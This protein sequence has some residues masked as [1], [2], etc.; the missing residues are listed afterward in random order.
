MHPSID[1]ECAY[2]LRCG[3]EYRAEIRTCA[4]C[5]IALVSG[6]HLLARQSRQNAADRTL[7]IEP[8]EPL[9]AVRRGPLA[10]IK[11]LHGYLVDR[12]LPSL[13]TKEEGGACG[14]RGPEVV[15]QVREADLDEVMAALAQEYLHSTGLAEHDTRFAGGVY[16]AGAAEAIC[17]ACGCR[18]STTSTVC[19]DCG[20]CFA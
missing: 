1:P 8:D 16:D 3:D 9:V 14:C 19:P 17:P 7:T 6:A 2:C 11:A 15:L 10:Q 18:F 5:G 13:V 4:S 20:L 12:G